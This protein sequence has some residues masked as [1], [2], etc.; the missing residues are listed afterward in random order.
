MLI[1]SFNTIPLNDDNHKTPL[2]DANSEEDI[3]NGTVRSGGL[4]VV[5]INLPQI[6]YESKG[7]DEKLY[8]ILRD[9][10]EKAKDVLLLKNKI[11][12]KNLKH[13]MLPFMGQVIDDKGT[14][15]LNVDKQSYIIGIIGM[16][17][18]L[19]AHTGEELHEST[20][21]WTFGLKV[22]KRMKDIVAEFRDE[23]GL[24]FALARTPAE[25]AASRLAQIDRRNY[26]GAAVFQG[27]LPDA[28][29][30]TNSFQL[31]PSADV[32]LFEKL[33]IEGAF[34][35]LTDGGAL[36]QIWLGEKHPDPEALLSLTKKI[37]TKTAIQYFPYTRDLS[38]CNV[39]GATT[40][41][42]YEKCKNCGAENLDW[43][44][45]EI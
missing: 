34:H 44:K 20:S 18:L 13:K 30:Y 4:Q 41:G 43:M 12:K 5:T 24:N 36:T 32:P 33:K 1:S 35:P 7:D 6:A 27:D 38:V 45:K 23:T 15:Y 9:R 3:Q 17:E 14:P 21:A 42:L 16:N 8:E 31:R 40:G 19:K 39:C 28:I 22:M 2:D 29:Y 25:S 26:D 11:I 37:A 10:M